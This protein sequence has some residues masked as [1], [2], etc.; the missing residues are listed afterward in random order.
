MEILITIISLHVTCSRHDIPSWIFE[1]LSM[2]M[3]TTGNTT[4]PG[5]PPHTSS[6]K[7]EQK[8]KQE[9]PQHSFRIISLNLQSICAKKASFMNLVDSAKPDIIFGTESWLRPDMHNSEFTPP[10]YTVIARRDIQDGY[11]GV[12]IMA[13]SITPCDELYTSKQSELVAISVGRSNNQP[14]IVAGL[15]RPPKWYPRSRWTNL[16]WGTGIS[17]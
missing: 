10:G 16:H 13:K 2:S 5:S 4:H 17:T 8:R 12:F 11:D 9:S 14:L 6:P 15:C 1:S 7:W 3:N